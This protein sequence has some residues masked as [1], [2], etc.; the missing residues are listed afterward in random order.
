MLFKKSSLTALI[1]SF[2]LLMVMVW[3]PSCQKDKEEDTSEVKGLLDTAGLLA[4]KNRMLRENLFDIENWES[5]KKER[6]VNCT[7]D[8]KFRTYS[9]VCNDPDKP[10]MGAVGTSLSRNTNPSFDRKLSKD[11]LLTPNPRTITRKLLE[12]PKG[13]FDADKTLNYLSVA[14]LQ[15][16]IHDRA[17]HADDREL[18]P[19][20]EIHIPNDDTDPFCKETF[21]F[22][23]SKVTDYMNPNR[24]DEKTTN[25]SGPGCT[26]FKI[27]K[28]ITHPHTKG[29][30]GYPNAV[31]HWS[32]AS[33]LYGSD[34]TTAKRLRTKG[35]TG[36][37]L[38]IQ[39]NGL[40]PVQD[41]PSFFN[42][43]KECGRADT[44]FNENW[45]LGLSMM[46]LLFAKEHNY[47]VDQLDSR[48]GGQSE[49]WL[50][51]TARLIVGALITRIH[52]SEWSPAV[53]NPDVW[54]AFNWATETKK[55]NTDLK[56]KAYS[57][58]EDF[59]GAYRMHTLLRDSVDLYKG[60]KKKETKDLRDMLNGD[61][62][63]IQTEY[64]QEDLWYSFARAH[65][66]K[67]ALGNYPSALI[68]ISELFGYIK[69]DL[70]STE[71]VRDRERGLP[72]YNSLRK[73]IGMRGIK[74]WDEFNFPS[75]MKEKLIEIYGD[76]EAGVNK[77][78]LLVGIHAEYHHK[79]RP[80]GFMFGE[81]AFNIFVLSSSRRLMTDQFF[82]GKFNA[83]YYTQW[84]MDHVEKQR[85]TDVILRHMPELKKHLGNQ[86]N[87]FLPWTNA[88]RNKTAGY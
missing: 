46:H 58:T 65:P 64:S 70:A 68:N 74:S 21:G 13:Y 80:R 47:V 73:G 45:W 23:F 12:R 69:F 11:N 72:L 27:R 59:V 67:V 81:V 62:E 66:G 77:M 53:T 41:C 26:S 31:T 39:K 35:G 18:E 5:H 50:Y 4:T 55:R 78:D 2:S 61:A 49:E 19:E 17:G 3:L 1:V 79:D 82:R 14:F 29:R 48:Y 25:Y 63:V 9:G 57:H 75:G 43:E 28:T 60:G 15:F 87:A 83:T 30:R 40:L 34:E 16:H 52:N 37:K 33:Q 86:T 54:T 36:A 71:I 32:D 20:I 56:G 22:Y 88:N 42:Q 76:G 7:N 6:A 38:I 85:M 24:Q 44:G 51:Q 84:G 8:G 10:L